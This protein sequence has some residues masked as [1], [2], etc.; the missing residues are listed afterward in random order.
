MLD[1][2]EKAKE[3]TGISTDQTLARERLKE[4]EDTLNRPQ[5]PVNKLTLTPTKPQTP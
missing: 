1:E 3:R 4:N 5:T 2:R